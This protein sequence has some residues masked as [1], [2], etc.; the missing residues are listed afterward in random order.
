MTGNERK[1]ATVG[2]ARAF[3][4]KLLC[5]AGISSYAYDTDEILADTEGIERMELFLHGRDPLAHAEIFCSRIRRRVSREPLQHILGKCDF[6]GRT[7]LVTRDVL[8]PRFDT[9]S[10]VEAI[11]A[12]RR[13]AAQ[14][15][16][17]DL[18]TGSG[19][20]LLTILSEIPEA[21]GTGTDLS[22]AAL[23]LAR[24]NAERLALS[25]EFF[26][27]D[28]FSALPDGKMFDLIVSNPPYIKSA[29]IDRLEPEVSRFE[30]RM[31][32]DGGADGLDFY[33]KIIRQAP[34]YLVPGGLLYFEIGYDEADAVA[35]LMKS[36][37]FSDV[38]V[39]QDLSG[40]DRVVSGMKG[41]RS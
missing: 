11:L 20:I 7:F 36:D 23:A 13:L 1:P 10:L 18:C 39:R 40:R 28:L 21:F 14:P 15:E 29:E 34:E 38:T 24:K 25:A 4:R 32:L 17:L 9:E 41:E 27:G 19:C 8:T 33:R 26:A 3:G 5:R 31:A 6:F 30:P 12:D 22:E 2:E 16:I 35:G 37:G